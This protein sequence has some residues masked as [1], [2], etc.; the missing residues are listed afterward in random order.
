M[1]FFSIL[2]LNWNQ[3]ERTQR[4]IE[5]IKSQTFTDYEIILID[6][7]STDGSRDFFSQYQGITFVLNEKNLGFAEGNNRG[8]PHCQGKWVFFLNN[9]A[10]LKNGSSLD[11][12]HQAIEKHADEKW[13]FGPI[14]LQN[15]QPDRIDSGGDF[16]YTCGTTFKYYNYPADH[17]FFE[18]DRIVSSICGGACL[19]PLSLVKELKGFDPDFFLTC[20]DLDFS[21]R[22]FHAG[23]RAKIIG[24]VH[25]YHEGS[26]SM[27]VNSP[28]DTYFF[29]RNLFWFKLKNYPL[30]LILK[31]S[32]LTLFWSILI[33][34]Q[35]LRQG[36]L[37]PYLKA[38]KDQIT[39][40]P[41]MLKKRHEIFL[42]SRCQPAEFAQL[43]RKTWI[44]EKF[45]KKKNF[46]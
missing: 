18:N 6:N 43:F 16:L 19:A 7:H 40:I 29:Y 27:G 42:N 20:E 34:I 24:N 2:I 37:L 39:G 35:K 11:R 1:P 38:K 31:Q 46:Y 9:D 4:C 15:S 21:F 5:Y 44:S 25:V 26:A 12:L 3:C 10:Y 14:M 22:A 30:N 32:P 17:S 33:F 13:I 23:Y 45:L 36:L 8:I 41:K 28:T